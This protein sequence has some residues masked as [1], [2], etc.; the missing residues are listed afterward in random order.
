MK[1]SSQW[2]FSQRPTLSF[3]EGLQRF[4]A[5]LA[6]GEIRGAFDSARPSHAWYQRGRDRLKEY[7]A[8]AAAGGWPRL[9]DGPT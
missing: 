7:R 4:S 3:D 2:N 6:A 8:I 9:A 5:R 1:L